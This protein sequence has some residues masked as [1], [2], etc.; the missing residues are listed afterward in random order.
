MSA[1]EAVEAPR[2][3]EELRRVIETLYKGLRVDAKK[4][5]VEDLARE[6]GL[7]VKAEYCGEC[8][9][10]YLVHQVNMFTADIVE[11]DVWYPVFKYYRIDEV[12]ILV[13]TEDLEEKFEVKEIGGIKALYWMDEQHGLEY[14]LS[15][16]HI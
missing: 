7:D 2:W 16:I 14:Y 6:L 5:V 12:T 4:K 8:D 10:A 13:T 9:V 11:H 3:A 15:L 1:V